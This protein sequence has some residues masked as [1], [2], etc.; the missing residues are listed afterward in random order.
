MLLPLTSQ[1]ETAP[2][3]PLPVTRSSILLDP[4]VCGRRCSSGE[5]EREMKRERARKKGEERNED[6]KRERGRDTECKSKRRE[7]ELKER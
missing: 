2:P 6:R 4:G 5:G 3:P 7:K 1:P